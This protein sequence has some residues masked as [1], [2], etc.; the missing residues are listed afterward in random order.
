LARITITIEGWD[1]IVSKYGRAAADQALSRALEQTTEYTARLVQMRVK[2]KHH[3]TG[4]LLSSIKGHVATTTSGSVFAEQGGG[5]YYAAFVEHGTGVWG[6]RGTPI[7]PKKAKAL[8]WHPKTAT[9]RPDPKSRGNIVRR[10]VQ[11]QKPVKMFHETYEQD[12][13]K[14]VDKFQTAFRS[15]FIR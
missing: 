9:G 3:V 2:G 10:S 7:V 15:A 14:I 12:R 13:G 8:A 4:F 6:P 5:V 11:G 1:R